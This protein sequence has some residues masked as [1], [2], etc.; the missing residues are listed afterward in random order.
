MTHESPTR[1]EM[2]ARLDATQSHTLAATKPLEV[3]MAQFEQTVEKVMAGFSDLKRT[4]VLTGI[5]TVLGVGALNAAILSN[6]QSSF[7]S[8]KVIGLDISKIREE[9][10]TERLEMMA[11]LKKELASLRPEIGV[12]K[13]EVLDLRE[14]IGIVKHQLDNKVDRVPGK[15]MPKPGR[16]TRELM[17]AVPQ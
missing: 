4:V 12:L 3:R 7:E 10:R 5:S 6:I 13:G 2:N 11:D 8:G 9:M 15:P 16:P 17:L 14:H 1:A